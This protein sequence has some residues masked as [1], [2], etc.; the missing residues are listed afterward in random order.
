MTLQHIIIKI[1]GL[2]I[3]IHTIVTINIDSEIREAALSVKS[4]KSQFKITS[5]AD[6]DER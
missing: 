3:Y 5:E 6:P 4:V 2:N 1:N